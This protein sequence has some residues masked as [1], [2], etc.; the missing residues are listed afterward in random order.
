MPTDMLT[1]IQQGE[2]LICDGAMGTMLLQA[3]LQPG[4]CAE[5]W[6][7]DRPEDVAEIHKEY[8]EV[9]CDMVIT[10]TFGGTRFKLKKFN[11]ENL[12]MKLNQA[13]AQIA[14][15]V[16]DTY[17]H[18]YVL[19]DIGPTGEF[20]QPLGELTYEELYTAFKEQAVALVAGGVDAIIIETMSAIEEA[21]CAV[22]AVKENTKMPVIATMTFN[23][24]GAQGF[25]T[26]FGVSP[27]QA[28]EQLA[29]AG[30]DIIGT[31]CGGV[32][33]EQMADIIC[34]MRKYTAK[35]LIAEPNAGLPKLIDGKT[36]YD[37]SP[38]YMASLAPKLV[39]AGANIIGGCCGTTPT[40]LKAIAKAIKK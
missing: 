7:I 39:N 28:A 31:N 35:P 36:V 15:A 32:R 16:A 20:L 34:E 24:A 33:V 5:L 29:A 23:P 18:R 8:F 11:Q 6:N 21:V 4:H 22:R 30:A 13:G 10:N 17:P 19:G 27:Q 3:G 25:R 40:H 2:I 14:R 1:R 38:E 37:E 9:G 12:V 26:M